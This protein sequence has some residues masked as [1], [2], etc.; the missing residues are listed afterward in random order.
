MPS[1]GLIKGFMKNYKAFLFLNYVVGVGDVFKEVKSVIGIRSEKT[2]LYAD[3]D[4]FNPILELSVSGENIG[5]D[6]DWEE[7]KVW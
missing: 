2:N 6:S 1:G 5:T 3:V 4:F 7:T